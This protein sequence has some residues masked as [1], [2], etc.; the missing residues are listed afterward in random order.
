[1]NI[2]TR[3]IGDVEVSAMEFGPLT[4]DQVNEINYI[5]ERK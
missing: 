4:K 3:K 5:L 2:F 1:M